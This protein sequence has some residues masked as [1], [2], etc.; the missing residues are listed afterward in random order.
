M[1]KAFGYDSLSPDA[2]LLADKR[3][4]ILS[5]LYGLLRPGDII[6]PYRLEFT[7]RVAPGDETMARFLKSGITAGLVE[8]LKAGHHTDVI[9]MLP[10]DAAKAVDWRA[11]RDVAGVWT[12]DFREVIEGGSLR[13]PRANL[14]KK[15]RGHLLRS[16]ME[17][18]ADTPGDIAD[19]ETDLLLPQTAECKDGH[20]VFHV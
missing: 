4:R 15:L 1:F 3:L 10:G 13:T 12:V 9:N 11:I 16:I 18:G 20:I 5:S 8:E 17:R 6:K 19:I 14:L 7:A 2:K